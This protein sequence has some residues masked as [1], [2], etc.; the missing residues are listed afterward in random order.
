MTQ[1][2]IDDR[3][4]NRVVVLEGTP[5]GTPVAKS[6]N[7]ADE[8]EPFVTA[9]IRAHVLPDARERFERAVAD[10]IVSEDGVKATAAVL[11]GTL[12][13]I[14]A[15]AKAYAPARIT[16]TARRYDDDDDLRR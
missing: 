4:A 13:Y 11:E 6:F 2:N 10:R 5:L 12:A 7:T 9:R 14:R 15:L 3:D 8:A 1:E 16:I